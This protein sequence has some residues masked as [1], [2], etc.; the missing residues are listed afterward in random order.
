M[1][2]KR[3]I[4]FLLY[5]EGTFL[6]KG[7]EAIVNTTIKKIK[8][9]CDGKI[10]LATNDYKYDSKYY[11]DII[12]KYVQQYYLDNDLSEEEREK[13]E[14]Y[15]TIPYDYTNFEKI[16][17]KDCIKEIENVDICL[18]V[19]GDNYC[20]GEPYWLY[21]INKCIKEKGKKNV[22][23]CTSIY[24]NIESDEMIRDLKTY[25]VVVT[26][27]SLTYNALAKFMDK[28]RIMLTPDTAF[29]L[30]KKETSLPK[31]FEKTKKVVGINISPLISQYTTKKDNILNSI[32]TLIEYILKDNDVG[33]L[34]LPHVYIETNRDL[35]ALGKVKELFKDNDRVEILNDR[36]YDCEEIKYIISNCNYLVAARTHASIA[37][38]S[39]LVPTLVIGYSVK[40]KGIA[41]DLFGEY[42]NYVIPV[43][44]MTPEILLEKF[45]F[46]QENEEK[47]KQILKEKMVIY[48]EKADNQL[49]E[50]LD[51]LEYLD[52][53]YITDKCNCTG[54]M[55]CYNICPHDAIEIVENDKGF[56]YTK[57]NNEK[58]INCGLCKKV[59]PANKVY[60]NVFEKPEFYAVINNN[61]NDRMNSSSGGTVGAISKEI[62]KNKG[63]VYGATLEN[64]EVKHIRV[65][66]EK[67]IYKIMG[68]K[69]LQ[70]K[71]GDCYTQVKE[72]LENN[73]NVLFTG[74]PCQIEG[75]KAY[76]NKEYKNLI[77]LSIICHGVPSPKV[78][79]KYL[80]EKEEQNKS[81][82][83]NVSFRNKKF[84][85]HKYSVSYEYENGKNELIP[86]IEDYYMQGFLKNYYLRESCY[87]CQMRFDK[88]N[89]ADIIVGDFWGIEN[90]F[91][92]IDD[93]KGVSAVIVNSEIGLEIF[94]KIKEKVEYKETTFDDIIKSNPV[95]TSPTPYTK[96]EE[97][98]YE[99]IK[100]YDMEIV[101]NAL[102]GMDSDSEIKK[103]RDESNKLIDEIN[104]LNG[105]IKDLLEAKTYFLG[106]IE[107]RDLQLEQKENLIKEKENEIQKIYYSRRWKYTSKIASVF[108]KIKKH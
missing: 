75:L 46:I 58:C 1:K 14:Y 27:E 2:E 103:I 97:K 85:W 52:K 7:C 66:D 93:D 24:E 73:K 59:C 13:I 78:F 106:Q 29:S 80:E 25:D 57:I 32:K 53:K 19:G 67:D 64:K 84:G 98:F 82:I 70:S 81:K 40:S 55:A 60:K 43:D 20:Y 50:L 86:F 56:L 3:K 104:I 33:V 10:I 94:N 108:H 62:L 31:I 15:K 45:K 51:R 26:R 22:F 77:A 47:I 101:V 38:Y 63:V 68:S 17:K 69:Y 54:C 23:W 71:I 30:E 5:G 44:E 21:T 39:T 92:E 49:V 96:K 12:T 102:K 36:I 83:K 11:N 107:L 99:L 37:G 8:N 28:D 74:T 105:Q 48:K 100:K 18:S 4:N 42:E 90:V 88:K 41:L 91:P 16:Y 89:S 65:D 72:D 34:L 79:K 95:L 61:Q 6:N 76:L 87:N 35:D 9:A